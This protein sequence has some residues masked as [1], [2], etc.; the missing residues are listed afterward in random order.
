MTSSYKPSDLA[1]FGETDFFRLGDDLRVS[2]DGLEWRLGA[3]GIWRSSDRPV[4]FHGRR[5]PTYRRG[6]L[7]FDLPP[8][9]LLTTVDFLLA[10]GQPATAV[11]LRTAGEEVFGAWTRDESQATEVAAFLN[12]ELESLRRALDKP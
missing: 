12:R 2:D 4:H 5:V 1:V 9:A 8:D 7:V 6:S 3:L 10:S 11:V